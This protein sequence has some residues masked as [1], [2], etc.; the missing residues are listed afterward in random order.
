MSNGKVH[1]RT[2]LPTPPC[3]TKKFHDYL[4]TDDP[5]K[6]T[7]KKCKNIFEA[8]VRAKRREN[9]LELIRARLCQ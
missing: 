3:K 1:L 9:E 7:C 4:S 6:L 2:G 8:M 5:D